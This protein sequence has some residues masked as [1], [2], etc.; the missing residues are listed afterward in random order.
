MKLPLGKK[1]GISKQAKSMLKDI[2]KE[3]DVSTDYVLYTIDNNWETENADRILYEKMAISAIMFFV[4]A[5]ISQLVV[6]KLFFK[7]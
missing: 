1:I 2:C 4:L 3:N 6:D 7:E 5:I